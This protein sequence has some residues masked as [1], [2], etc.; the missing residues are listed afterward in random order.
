ML[1]FLLISGVQTRDSVEKEGTGMAE[2]TSMSLQRQVYLVVGTVVLLGTLLGAFTSRGW[3]LI[4][5]LV[6]IG[7]LYAA[8]TGTCRLMMLLSRLPFN[9]PDS[10]NIS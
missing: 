7:L 4:P 9:K 8:R 2:K 10:G 5:A 3:L 1:L 6:G